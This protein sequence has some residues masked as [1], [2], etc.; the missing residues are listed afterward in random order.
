MTPAVPLG[1]DYLCDLCRR[2]RPRKLRIF[3]VRF[4][5]GYWACAACYRIYTGM[6][7]GAEKEGHARATRA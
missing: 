3:G 7:A 6:L 5:D 2:L 4:I 1:N